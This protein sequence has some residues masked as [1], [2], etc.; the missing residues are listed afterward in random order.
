[1]GWEQKKIV[2]ASQNCKEL[3]CIC[4]HRTRVSWSSLSR[5]HPSLP[6]TLR[7]RNPCPQ[8]PVFAEHK[9]AELWREKNASF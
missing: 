6:S 1:M 9:H 2:Q 7:M 5:T 8:T 3:M 4:L